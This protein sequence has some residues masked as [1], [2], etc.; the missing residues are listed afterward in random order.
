MQ[1]RPKTPMFRIW[2]TVTRIVAGALEIEGI[3]DFACVGDE[4]QITKNNKKVLGEV[5]SVTKSR[6]MALLYS[7]A[8]NVRIGDVVHIRQDATIRISDSWLGRIVNY[9]GEIHGDVEQV[10]QSPVRQPLYGVAPPAHLRRHLGTRL[11]TG[12]MVTDTLLPICKGQRIGLFAGSGVGKS[13]L[14]G[15]LSRQVDA[16]RIVIALIGERSREVIEFAKK[17]L[18]PELQEK[19][20]IVASTS[21]EPPG[22]KKRAAYCAMAAAEH[23]SEQGHDVL[24]VCDSLTRFAEAHRETALMAGEQP[25]LNAFPPSTN[26]VIAELAERAGPGT[27]GTGDITAIFS[28]LVAGS[29]MEEPVTDMIRGILDGHIILDRSIAERGR[30]P[31]IDVARSVSRCLPGAAT[32]DENRLL[33]EYRRLLTLY[34]EVAPM[35]RASLYEFGQDLETDRAVRLYPQIDKFVSG[36]NSEKIEEAFVALQQILDNYDE[37]GTPDPNAQSN[38][39]A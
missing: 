11:N 3:S 30:Y 25:A 23:F 37:T 15:T 24:L 16:D 22:A 14:L 17:T 18:T 12:L 8:D 19:A 21:S 2:G 33:H 9:R 35:L 6:V 20:V 36:R 38:K 5:L 26:R 31:A 10:D 7:S 39:A 13:T 29:D 32:D 34:E 1:T 4:I 27:E 28:V